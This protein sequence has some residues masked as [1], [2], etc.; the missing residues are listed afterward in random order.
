MATLAPHQERV[1]FE[2]EELE[3]KI[4]KLSNFLNSNTYKELTEDEQLLLTE[5]LP[6]MKDYSDVLFKRIKLFMKISR[7]VN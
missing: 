4:V 7:E 2:R 1:I 6:I 3:D 5:Q